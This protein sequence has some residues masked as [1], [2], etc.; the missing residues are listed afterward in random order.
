MGKVLF[1]LGSGAILQLLGN[2]SPEGCTLSRRRNSV[3]AAADAATV[4]SPTSHAETAAGGVPLWHQILN[5]RPTWKGLASNPRLANPL[6]GETFQ[7]VKQ[8]LSNVPI[9]NP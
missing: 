7:Q 3:D 6:H 2:L 4:A 9:R 8:K 5:T 1:S